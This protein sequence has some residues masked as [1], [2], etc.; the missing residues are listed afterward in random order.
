MRQLLVALSM[1][2]SIRS[3]CKGGDTLK[4]NL[5][6]IQLGAIYSPEYTYRILDHPANV[7]WTKIN[8]AWIEENRK[9][10]S[11]IYGFATGTSL[12][13]LLSKHVALETGVC[14]SQKGYQLKNVILLP[15]DTPYPV[16]SLIGDFKSTYK[17]IE[18]PLKVNYKFGSKK[19]DYF[20][21][22]GFAT[23]IFMEEKYE[24]RIRSQDNKETYNHYNYEKDFT[25]VDVA[26]VLGFGVN[27]HV[28]KKIALMIEPSYTQ[29]ITPL[30]W[31]TK[32]NDYLYALGAG[33]GVYYTFGKG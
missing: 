22:A 19:I 16:P 15:G 21:S 7:A 4:R 14:Y 11:A 8:W 12:K 13:I 10:E 23:A 30:M 17:F 20:I 33:L 2:I 3:F 29:F 25:K 1:M 18:I 24:E 9:E 5:T 31:K 6:R 32:D 28:T 27:Y 26:A